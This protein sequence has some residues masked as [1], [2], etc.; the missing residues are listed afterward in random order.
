MPFAGMFITSPI[1]M[2]IKNILNVGLFL[3]LLQSIKW[4]DSEDQAIRRGEFIELMMLTLFGMYLMVSA[5]HFLI[6]IIGLE[7]ASLPLLCFGG[8]REEGLRITRGRS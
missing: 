7:T 8:I 4:N 1:V 2:C 5:R 3:V 6:F